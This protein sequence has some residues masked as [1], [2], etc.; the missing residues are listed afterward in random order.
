MEPRRADVEP[1]RSISEHTAEPYFQP[2]CPS[3]E[4]SWAEYRNWFMLYEEK[5]EVQH[6]PTYKISEDYYKDTPPDY[7]GNILNAF[8]TGATPGHIRAANTLGGTSSAYPTVQGLGVGKYYI[9]MRGYAIRFCG[10]IRPPSLYSVQVVG[11]QNLQ[12]FQVSS[13]V[14][15]DK[16]IGSYG[17]VRVIQSTWDI[18]Y[19]IPKPLNAGT[20]FITGLVTDGRGEEYVRRFDPGSVDP[21]NNNNAVIPP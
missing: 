16:V 12:P 1:F 7:Q 11:G 6:T 15:L 2:V 21:L 20:N 10:Q 5:A 4:K 9:R 8:P 18:L 19:T 17:P 3:P 13:E 14:V